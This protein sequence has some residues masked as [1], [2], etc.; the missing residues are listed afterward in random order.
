MANDF[1]DLANY[2]EELANSVNE[3]SSEIAKIY[4]KELITG[5]IKFSPV[6]TSELISNWVIS[7]NSKPQLKLSPHYKGKSGS[8]QELSRLKA[9]LDA[10]T[11]LSAKKPG[12]T[13][14]ISNLA[15]QVV[16]TNYG[17][18][19]I[20]PMYFIERAMQLAESRV[21]SSEISTKL[22]KLL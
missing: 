21:N 8:T 2:L 9:L 16:Y 11:I 19:K 7:I 6:D 22:E 14:Y 10:L 5:L 3:A 20:A 4:A 18:T 13:I 1:L 17:T 15:P 12:D